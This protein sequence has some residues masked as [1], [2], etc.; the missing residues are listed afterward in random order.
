MITLIAGT[1]TF[2]DYKL[3]SEELSKLNI[4]EI[5]SGGARGADYLAEV[6]AKENNIPI[7]VFPAQWEKFGK[8]AGYIRNKEMWDYGIDLCVLFWDGH[9]KGTKHNID[10]SKIYNKKVIIINYLENK[11]EILE[12]FLEDW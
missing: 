12:P 1:R 8:K 9:S 3:L 10:L 4:T 5:I 7:K 6:Y 2:N 11:K